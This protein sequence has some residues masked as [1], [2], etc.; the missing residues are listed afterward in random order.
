MSSA[1]IRERCG[2]KFLILSRSIFERARSISGSTYFG[3][4]CRKIMSL[5]AM[6]GRFHSNSLGVAVLVL[7]ASGYLVFT[8]PL[9]SPNIGSGGVQ[10]AVPGS[11]TPSLGPSLHAAESGDK[12]RIS[13]ILPTDM[14]LNKAGE[15]EAA[16]ETTESLRG[17]EA[18]EIEFDFAAGLGLRL[19][20]MDFFSRPGGGGG[21]DV[22]PVYE[23]YRVGPG[24]EIL[25]RAWGQVDM[26][27][28]LTV[29]RNG[30]INIPRV[31]VIPVANLQ[32]SQLEGF[33]KARVGQL[34]RNFEM[35]VTLGRLRSIQ[36]FVVGQAR[37][38]G[39]YTVSAWSSLVNALIASG[40][41]SA[42]GTMRSIQVKRAGQV[43]ATFDLYDLLMKG[44]K[45]KDI[46]IKHGDVIHIPARGNAAGITGQ[47]KVP[48]VYEL[49]GGETVED[50]LQYAENFTATAFK[51]RIHIERI[52][53]HRLRE[54][55]VLDW[56]L[57][58]SKAEPVRNGD[59]VH[60]V[61]ISPRFDKVVTLAG[62]VSVP[63]RENWREG[64]RITDLIPRRTDL[65]PHSYWTR[66]NRLVNQRG[67]AGGN[68]AAAGTGEFRLRSDEVR[69]F[70]DLEMVRG[71]EKLLDEI[72]W[73]YATI[74]RI[75]T[76]S[77]QNELITFNLGKALRENDPEHNL[78]LRPGDVISIFKRGNK[79]APRS[80]R[81]EFVT[82]RGEVIS[83]GVYEL[84]PNETLV[85][86]VLRAGG[87]TP[88]A[89][90][91]ASVFSRESVRQ[92]QQKRLD[93]G[94]V[95][96]EKELA[97][98]S[99]RAQARTTSVESKSNI[100]AQIEARARS[101]N[102]MRSTVATGRI[103]LNLPA[104]TT[105]PQS[106]P[107][108]K[109]KDGDNFF[110]PSQIDEV[111]V[112]GEVF[113]QQSTIWKRGNTILDTM[114]TAGGPTR[115]ANMKQLF[116]I[117]ADGTVVS[118]GQMGRRFIKTPMYPG[119]TLVVP[120]EMD[121]AN[122]K[123]ELK[124]WAQIFADFAIGAAAIRVLRGN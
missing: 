44:D 35:N 7:L 17:E 89:Y 109:L 49:K 53:D 112:M 122:W 40:G 3:F 39:K 56:S 113:N 57:P 117:R 102:T 70:R 4:S 22:L 108:V 82:L 121:F 24:D 104:N 1:A 45:S 99:A 23:D 77:L 83:P 41:P 78:L 69:R 48:A 119:D 55:K 18:L 64:M 66:K 2:G 30:D 81:Q 106:L 37:R 96:M 110:V 68:V 111:H 5:G 46:A 79:L 85:D 28:R 98:V 88:E 90:P 72:N 63:R 60:V 74:Q 65:I 19:F 20:G 21:L 9:P 11:T 25:I 76:E 6:V 58:A 52:K 50:L 94:I 120:E 124:E 73:E 38:P 114:A 10:P 13:N 80:V 92:E 86:L 62:H 115:H 26:N 12:P 34:F 105:R 31:G 29:D 103:T 107:D 16:P 118:Y 100:A 71:A 8:Q 47:V 32:A 27:L 93:E 75:D 87:F 33:I 43:V 84:R 59:M 95:R 42:V 14:S 101:I 61:P 123:Y 36:V 116:L 97:Q 91:Y 67:S 15:V 54:I 51:G